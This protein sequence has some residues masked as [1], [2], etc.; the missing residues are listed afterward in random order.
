MIAKNR[1]IEVIAITGKLI[2]SVLTFH[3]TILNS[4][5]FVDLVTV[6]PL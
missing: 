1:M 6:I 4:S 3:N 2:F 5:D